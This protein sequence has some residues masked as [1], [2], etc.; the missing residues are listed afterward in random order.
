[1]GYK[2]KPSI[3]FADKTPDN[4]TKFSDT[5]YFY[6]DELAGVFYEYDDKSN[7]KETHLVFVY[8]YNVKYYIYTTKTIILKEYNNAFIESLID[9]CPC[10]FKKDGH[11]QDKDN[12][13]FLG[14]K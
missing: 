11:P 6:A 5:G 8:G 7:L 2:L 12:Q 4:V 14:Y 1:M 10:K 13:K 9:E 3:P